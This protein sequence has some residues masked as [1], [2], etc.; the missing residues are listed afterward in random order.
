MVEDKSTIGPRGHSVTI[1]G[2]PST[3]VAGTTYSLSAVLSGTILGTGTYRWTVAGVVVVDYVLGASSISWTPTTAQIGSSITVNVDV[4]DSD[5]DVHF[6]FASFTRTIAAPPSP[7]ILPTP[8]NIN[9]TL[10]GSVY[11]PALPEASG[12]TGSYTYAVLNR[13]SWLGFNASTRIFTG[14]ETQVGF[15]NL[16]YQVTDSSGQ[17]ASQGFTYRVNAATPPQPQ[18]IRHFY[19]KISSSWRTLKLY[20]KINGNWS[21]VKLWRKVNSA[22]VQISG[23]I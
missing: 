17:T 6:A 11:S 15:W 16:T 4:F 3:A 21:E 8:S 23:P 22:W 7:L 9:R 14:T 18:F 19:R 20:R 5:L 13:P 10:G 12:G 2:I 1:N